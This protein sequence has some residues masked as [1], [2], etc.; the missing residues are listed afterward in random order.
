MIPLS[1]PGDVFIS[2]YFMTSSDKFTNKCC[3]V[4]R[5]LGVPYNCSFGFTFMLPLFK[6]G[7]FGT[8]V[9]ANILEVAGRSV[10]SVC[11]H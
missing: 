2:E 11:E 9:A 6:E 8:E 10:S 4:R 5:S 1:S 7:D 3:S